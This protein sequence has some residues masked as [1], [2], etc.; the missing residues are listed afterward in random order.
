MK[1]YISLLG[2][3]KSEAKTKIVRFLLDHEAPMSEREIA[4]VIN[5]SHMSVNRALQELAGMNL[6]YYV[7]VGKAHLW[8]VNRRS[9][10]YKAFREI[11]ERLRD[12]PDP[13]KE[14]KRV[15]L[16]GLPGSMVERIVLFGSITRGKETAGS[17]I[18]LFILVKTL[19]D[20]QKLEIP[21]E[22]LSNE[23]LE[24]FGNRLAPY[25]LTGR[26]FKQKKSLNIL[27][28]I[29]KGIQLYPDGNTAV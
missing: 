12:V 10:A 7:T 19:E 18:D 29:N 9:F 1:F 3:F 6:V 24:L 8:K 28:E 5:V 14:L 22:K 4:S 16:K 20:Q 13:L 11:L 25:I 2:L 17:D 23:C 26:Q 27:A 21:L 15:I